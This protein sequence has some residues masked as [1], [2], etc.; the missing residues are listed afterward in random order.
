MSELKITYELRPCM[1]ANMKEGRLLT[2]LPCNVGDIVYELMHDE[3]AD[4]VDYISEFEVQDVSA[5]Q[6]KYADD[7]VDIG[8]KNLFLTREEAEEALE[9]IKK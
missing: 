2:I 5:R 7:W 9:K 4:P 3:V 6:I 1:V 8:Y